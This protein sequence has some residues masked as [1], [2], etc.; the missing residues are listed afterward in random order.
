MCV[1]TPADAAADSGTQAGAEASTDQPA[2]PADAKTQT[3]ENVERAE[4]A[5]LSVRQRYS[6]PAI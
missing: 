4:S 2:E 6:V 5:E 3:A 1:L